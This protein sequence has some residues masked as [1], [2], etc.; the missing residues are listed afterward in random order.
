MDAMSSGLWHSPGARWGM[1]GL[2]DVRHQIQPAWLAPVTFEMQL[3]KMRHHKL[4]SGL[5]AR[6]EPYS[7]PRQ[8]LSEG[9]RAISLEAPALQ[10]SPVAQGLGTMPSSR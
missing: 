3:W 10:H 9:H 5:I 4:A 6:H 7:R 8:V 1:P 2:H